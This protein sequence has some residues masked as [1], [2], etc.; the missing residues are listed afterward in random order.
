[1][2]K[3][4]LASVILPFLPNDILKG[5]KIEGKR[6]LFFPLPPAAR[7]SQQLGGGGAGPN[8][9]QAEA[10]QLSTFVLHPDSCR[11]QGGASRASRA[12]PPWSPSQTPPLSVSVF[13]SRGDRSMSQWHSYGRDTLGV[14]GASA[15]WEGGPSSHLQSHSLLGEH[16]MVSKQH[17]KAAFLGLKPGKALRNKDNRCI[18]TS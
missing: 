16:F 10:Q 15:P 17:R 13:V 12:I 11:T 1:M 6:W 4:W 18:K 14:A 7:K 3:A 2:Q 5:K 9:Q 8:M